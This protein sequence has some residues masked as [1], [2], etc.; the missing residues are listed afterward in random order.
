MS[1]AQPIDGASNPLAVLQQAVADGGSNPLAA[2]QHAAAYT[3]SPKELLE[4]W[5]KNFTS[6]MTKFVIFTAIQIGI[7]V[8]VISGGGIAEV[9][10]N[11]PKYRCSPLIMPFA[12][13]FGYDA[14]ENFNFC[15]KNIFNLNAGAVL[16]PVYGVMSNFTDIIGTISNV[17]NS[18]RY[19]IANL[20][21]GMER[22]MSSFRDR[23]QFILFSVRMS[24]FKI[25]NLM[26]RLYT[27]FYA[28]IFMGMSALQAAQNVGNNAMVEF[29]LEFCFDPDT[30]VELATNI[31]VPLSQ[32]EIGTKLAA[33]NGVNPIV[34]SKFKFMGSATPMVKLNGTIVSSKHY[35]YYETLKTW[36]EAGMHPDATPTPSL[37]VLI[38]LNTST[39]TLKLNGTVFS[40]YDESESPDVIKATQNL[41]EKHLNSGL[42][43]KPTVDYALGIQGTTQVLLANGTTKPISTI[44]ITDKI[45]QGGSVLGLVEEMVHYVCELPN[46][47]I[48][49][50]AAQLLWNDNKWVRAASIYPVIK[51]K[52]PETYYQLITDLSIIVSSDTMFRDYREVNIPEMETAYQSDLLKA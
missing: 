14:S 45:S 22:L 5:E 20:L 19:L 4:S 6:N 21:H 50:S 49:V 26:G 42:H 37:P 13:F 33:I 44:T 31:I 12:G 38:C 30:P 27:T 41:A 18:F 35:V 34:T 24:F 7:V 48:K 10:N 1:L 15:M 46:T 28:V 16:A 43:N 8:W 39:H 47:G 32:V 2:L 40:D 25:M 9:V 11:W 52:T 3:P 23:F 51:L 29:L 36:I 17:A